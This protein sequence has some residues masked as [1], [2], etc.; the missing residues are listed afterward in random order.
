MLQKLF[1]KNNKGGTDKKNWYTDRYQAV[2][3]QRNLLSVFTLIALIFST[4]AIFFVYRNIPIVTV[5]PFVIQVEPKSG[6]TQ[7]VNSQT[8][9][10]ITAQ[11][12]INTYFIV[13]YIKARETIDSALNYHYQVVRLMSAPEVFRPYAWRVSPTNPESFV[14]KTNGQGL[15]DVKIR[16]MARMDNNANCIDKICQVQVRV[17]IIENDGRSKNTQHQ[18]I[19]MDYTFTNVNLTQYERYVNPIGFR[20]VSYRKSDEVLQ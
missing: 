12:S 9:R 19:Y 11:E 5:E 18:I 3:V 15:R 7:V 1:N 17:T 14:A 4:I 20:V 10:E 8:A 13:R 2:L 6:I 16:S